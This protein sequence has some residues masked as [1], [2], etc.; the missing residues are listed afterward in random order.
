MFETG[1]EDVV[2]RTRAESASIGRRSSAAGNGGVPLMGCHLP[3][4]TS[5]IRASINPQ[6]IGMRHSDDIVAAID[7]MDL[8]RH[9]G[10]EI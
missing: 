10:R 5:L 6:R 9:A 3:K 4:M 1:C 8:A 2:V 7:K